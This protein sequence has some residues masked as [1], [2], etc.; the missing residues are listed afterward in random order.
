MHGCEQVRREP[1]E[2]QK[3]KQAEAAA[4][5][6]ARRAAQQ[7]KLDAKTRMKVHIACCSCLSGATSKHLCRVLSI[8]NICCMSA[9][10]R[11]TV[12]ALN[13]TV[14]VTPTIP[15]GYTDTDM[16][17]APLTGQEP[18]EPAGGTQEGQH[19]RGQ[20]AGAAAAHH[21]AGAG[22]NEASTETEVCTKC[23]QD[24][25]HSTSAEAGGGGAG[26]CAARAAHILPKGLSVILLQHLCCSAAC[27]YFNFGLLSRCNLAQSD[28]AIAA[29]QNPHQS[30]TC[31][32]CAQ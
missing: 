5:H 27:A 1:K 23:R 13:V 4:A 6:A 7:A 11:R 25:R 29:N 19:H 3:E 9:S 28:Y 8:T 17:P 22:E 10:C 26:Q 20:K 24:A 12:I 32:T 30:S 31:S 18:A 15:G 16:P 2:V 21:G 14:V